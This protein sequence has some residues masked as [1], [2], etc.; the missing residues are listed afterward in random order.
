MKQKIKVA[1]KISE[2]QEALSIADLNKLT[3][4]IQS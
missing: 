1:L 2:N 4:Q 3:T